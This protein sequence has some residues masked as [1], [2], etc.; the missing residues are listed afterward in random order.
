MSTSPDGIYEVG[1]IDPGLPVKHSTQSYWFSQPSPISQLQ[2]S[3]WPQSADVVIIGSGMTAVSLTRTLYKH[4]PDIKIVVVEARNLCS[5][6]TGRNGGHCKAMSPGVWYDRK[7]AYGVDE[8]IRVMEYEH[9][10]LK[11]LDACAREADIICDINLV[12]GLD[13]YYDQTVFQRAVDALEDMRKYSP[14]LAARYAVYTS[15]EDLKARNLGTDCFGAIGMPAGTMW[16]YKLVTGLWEKMVK[17]NGVSIQTNTVVTSVSNIDNE[18]DCAI[19]RTTR[20]DIKA[21]QVVHATN[22][23]IGHLLHELRPFVS[24]VRANVQRQ[25]ARK[26]P[27]QLGSYSFW[28]RYGEKE[29]DYMIQR[30][31]G[32]FIIGRANTGR[33]ATADD[34]NKD[35]V[36]H[37]HLRYVTPQIFNLGT[38]ELDITHS[39]SG[40]VA[41]TQD[42]NPFVGRLPFPNRRNQWVCGAYQ[43]IGM[44]RAFR[45]AQML[46]LM[47]LGEEVPEEYP[48]SMLLTEDRVK[49]FQRVMDMKL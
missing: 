12:E 42:G 21:Q 27:A 48:R 18:G 30:A 29:Y 28:L 36:P 15:D 19:V 35:M 32:A 49:R 24:P 3:P 2:S 14:G 11:E 7:L 25:I 17:E 9:S 20:G 38:K 43:G 4:R 8:A 47:L 10:H 31:D 45:T 22:A 37:A 39:W 46:A 6:A 1:I 40:A 33:R 44:V 13:I 23:W 5:G 41:F 34:A 16:P 26:D